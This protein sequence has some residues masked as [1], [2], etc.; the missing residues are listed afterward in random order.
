MSHL[1]TLDWHCLPQEGKACSIS[2]DSRSTATNFQ[3]E[4]EGM[5]LLTMVRQPW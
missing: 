3:V 1:I 4:C 2:G 5:S